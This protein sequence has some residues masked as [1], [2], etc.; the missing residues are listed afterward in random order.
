MEK[1]EYKAIITNYVQ[2]RDA[3]L[4][5]ME[6]K[7]MPD[8]TACA[9]FS[10]CKVRKAWRNAYNAMNKVATPPPMIKCRRCGV[11]TDNWVYMKAWPEAF[12]CEKCRQEDED[13]YFAESARKVIGEAEASGEQPIPLA[14]VKKELDL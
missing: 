1:D 2:S 11:A 9:E 10:N 5:C 8:C 3:M 6:E 4:A 12:L 7:R 13:R 14:D